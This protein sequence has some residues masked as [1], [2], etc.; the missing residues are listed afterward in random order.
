M[1][2]S[3]RLREIGQ[4]IPAISISAIRDQFA[5]P[6]EPCDLLGSLGLD[7]PGIADAVL[8]LFKK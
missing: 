6:N 2:L 5:S 4:P 7:A 8:A 3:E 1:I